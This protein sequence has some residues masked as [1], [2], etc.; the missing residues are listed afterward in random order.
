MNTLWLVTLVVVAAVVIIL[1]DVLIRRQQKAPPEELKN[2]SASTSF[3]ISSQSPRE[4]TPSEKSV[5]TGRIAANKLE[6]SHIQYGFNFERGF[7]FALFYYRGTIQI[8]ISKC[9]AE[10]EFNVQK[11]M[12]IAL[13]RI[14]ESTTLESYTIQERIADDE[15]VTDSRHEGNTGKTERE[16]G[17]RNRSRTKIVRDQGNNTFITNKE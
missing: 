15:V 8:G 13:K 9:H 14:H 7:T 11:G 4:L 10:D 2:I 1:V 12:D 16:S 17:R 6:N 3:R 5:L